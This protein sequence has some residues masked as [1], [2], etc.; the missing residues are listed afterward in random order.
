MSDAAGFALQTRDHEPVAVLSGDWT[1]SSFAEVRD[2]F[3]AAIRPG[4][5]YDLRGLE[6]CDTVGALGILTFAGETFDPVASGARPEVARL[7]GLVARAAR[8]EPAPPEHPPSSFMDLFIRIG[9]GVIEF[10]LAFWATMAFTG[11]LTAALARAASHPGRIRW[12]PLVSQSQRSGLDAIPIVGVTSFFIGA[13]IAF[14]GA[15]LLATFSLQ[16]F[17]VELVGVAQL[18]E[19]AV[20]VTAVLLAGRSASSFAAEIGAM[21]MNQ[22]VDAMRVMG[23]EPFEALVLPRFLA[24]VFTIPLLTFIAMLAGLFGGLVVCWLQLGLSPIFF[25]QRISHAVGVRHFWVGMSKAPVMA[26]VIAAIGCRQGIQVGGDVES[27]GRRVT[28][29]VVHAIFSIILLDAVFAV[30]FTELNI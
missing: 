15:S 1:A 6:R 11:R 10:G 28:A 17:T 13:V 29:A 18:R 7:I 8:Q 2:R 3:R 27:L 5:H 30:I 25:V 16:V 26:M 4:L 12:A 22:E 20:V 23:V 14:I 21:N 19:F 24:L 9:R